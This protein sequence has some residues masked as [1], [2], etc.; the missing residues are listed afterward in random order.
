[1]GGGGTSGGQVYEELEVGHRACFFSNIAPSRRSR[2]GHQMDPVKSPTTMPVSYRVIS[3]VFLPVA[4]YNEE[5][6]EVSK[7]PQCGMDKDHAGRRRSPSRSQGHPHYGM[8]C[9]GAPIGLPNSCR[10]LCN[11][12]PRPRRP[13]A[14]VCASWFSSFCAARKSNAS[15]PLDWSRQSSQLPRLPR[16]APAVAGTGFELLRFSAAQFC[17]A[18]VALARLGHGPAACVP[19]AN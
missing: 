12:R 2:G 5:L 17:P 1:V 16:Q 3:R 11:R 10:P 19:P 14:I 9:V 15:P 7:N 18:L 13:W 6:S 4:A 8:V